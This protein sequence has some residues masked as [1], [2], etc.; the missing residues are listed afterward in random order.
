[1][2]KLLG[3][4]L[5]GLFILSGCNNDDEK[6]VDLT[7]DDAKALVNNSADKLGDDVVSL[8]ES[9]GAQAVID[10]ANLLE[11][12][13]VIG[14]RVSEKEWTK[15]RLNLIIQY[16]VNGPAART[17]NDDVTSLEDIQGLYEW[18]PE[19]GDFDKAESEFFIVKFPTE[20]SETN[21]A[22]L[23]I[24]ALEFVKITED[25]G[26]Y[27]DEYYLP[28]IIVGYV[29]VDE[30]TVIELDF[31]VNWSSVGAPEK[32][33]VS[34]FV[35][36]FNFELSFDDTFAQKSSILSSISI[37]D[38]LIVAIDL[39][40]EFESAEKEEPVYFEGSVTYRDLKIGG[41]VDVRDLPEDADPN[42]FINLALFS[43]DTKVGDI[44]FELEEIEPGFEDYVAYVE[45]SDGTKENLEDILEPVLQE[46]E[47]TFEEFED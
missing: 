24:S 30:T 3:V 8:V 10:F 36:P 25:H 35:S 23:K 14:G 16:F 20:G 22:E 31:E 1:M 44:V 33:E 34:L 28:S 26:E 12:S 2:K 32:A 46:I 17:S 41:D 21:N 47:E 7:A 19:I 13:A 4:L 9:D 43:G 6:N 18:N 29:K 45:Y 42:D 40:V 38:E 39:S 15:G 37:S 11:G 27:V 5:L